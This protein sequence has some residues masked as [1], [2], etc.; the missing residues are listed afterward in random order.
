[1]DSL[2]L[3]TPISA[4]SISASE[5]VKLYYESLLALQADE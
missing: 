1:L 5:D 4:K 3:M 2:Q